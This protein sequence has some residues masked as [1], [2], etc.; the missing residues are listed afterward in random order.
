M[1]ALPKPNSPSPQRALQL[2]DSDNETF[3]VF[4]W[5]NITIVIWP[6]QATGTA[7]KRLAKVTE[8]KAAEFREGFSNVHV[9]KNGAGM[10]TPEARAGFVEM[11][12]KHSKELAC[13]ST[14]L[15][16][17]GFWVSAL[18]SVTTGM[19]MISPRSFDHRINN[20]FEALVSWLPKEHRKRTGV[21]VDPRELHTVL[22]NAYVQVIGAPVNEPAKGA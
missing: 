8:L 4:G 6:S 2:L 5:Q 19:R 13:V 20:S 14:V 15:L 10:P 3:S 12:E 18:Q 17:S 1:N 7:V 9:V 22:D 11:M 21:S 16:G